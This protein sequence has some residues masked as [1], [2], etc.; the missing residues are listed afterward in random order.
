MYSRHLRRRAFTLIELL[1]VIAII[2][3]LIGLLLPAVQKVREAAARMKCANNLKQLALGCH[4]YES[5]YGFLPP[6][7][8]Y[9]DNTNATQSYMGWG[10]ATLPYIEQEPLFRQYDDTKLNSDPANAAVLATKVNVHMCPADIEAGK[11]QTCE[12]TGYNV[13]QQVVSSY[14]AVSGRTAAT[15]N[16]FWDYSQSFPNINVQQGSNK[17]MM[18]AAGPGIGVGEPL[19]KVIDGTSNTLMIGEYHTTTNLQRKAYWGVSAAFYSV[20]SLGPDSPTRGLT[21]HAA[22]AA[23]VVTGNSNRCNRAFASLHTGGGMNFA[24]GDGSVRVV[25]ST[26]DMNTW[27]GLGTMMGGEVTYLP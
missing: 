1:V 12:Y 2:A 24:M 3:V 9:K 5:S 27:V 23:L 13:R 21:D 11:L 17:G 6:A 25:Q 20:G 19:S 26:I 7:N 4:G 15:G 10:I 16:L 18:H 8:V 14:K 22:C